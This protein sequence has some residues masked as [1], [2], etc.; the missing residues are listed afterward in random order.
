V[1]FD[2]DQ[3]HAGT[4]DEAQTIQKNRAILGCFNITADFPDGVVNEKHL[5]F[6]HSLN[7]NL[8]FQT[9]KKGLKL[10]KQVRQNITTPEQVPDWVSQII[11]KIEALQDNVPSILKKPPIAQ[12]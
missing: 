2:G 8:G 6:T 9:S 11:E 10:F 3:N 1:I 12:A 7:E 5:G 4:A